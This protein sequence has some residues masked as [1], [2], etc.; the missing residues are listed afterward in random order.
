MQGRLSC[1]AAPTPPFLAEIKLASKKTLNIKML[2]NK[3]KSIYLCF[4]GYLNTQNPTE[5]CPNPNLPRVHLRLILSKQE[6]TVRHPHY[7]I[8]RICKEAKT[9]VNIS[10]Y[11]LCNILHFK[12]F[13]SLLYLSRGDMSGE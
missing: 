11:F 13:L 10:K 7:S 2:L 12:V 9:K 6:A 8:S 5:I 1:Q 4:L 3:Y